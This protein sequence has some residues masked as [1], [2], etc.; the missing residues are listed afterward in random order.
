MK[1]DFDE[2]EVIRAATAVI[3]NLMKYTPQRDIEKLLLLYDESPDFQLIDNDGAPK[4]ISQLKELYKGLFSSL[5]Y[6]KTLE[7]DIN[8]KAIDSKTAY[9]VWKGKEEIKMLESEAMESSWIATIIVK[10]IEDNW[11]IIHFHATH[12]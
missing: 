6:I 12:F 7:S 11:K 9:C 4:G 10:K 8:T 2:M 5:D 1:N 3:D